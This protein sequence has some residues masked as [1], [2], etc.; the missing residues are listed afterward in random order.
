MVR[1]EVRINRPCRIVWDYFTNPENWK[2]WTEGSLRLVP[3]KWEEGAT[4]VWERGPPSKIL[5]A[6]PQRE[7][8]IDSPYLRTTFRFAPLDD[9][10]TLIEKEF[11]AQRGAWFSDG[12][13]AQKAKE[14]SALAKLKQCVESETVEKDRRDTRNE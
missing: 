1:V 4:L 5:R 8:L 11:S 2:K 7:I 13:L 3:P 9:C 14:A 10:S 12:G 6:V